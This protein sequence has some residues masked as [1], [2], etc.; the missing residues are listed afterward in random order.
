MVRA[1]VPDQPAARDAQGVGARIDQEFDPHGSPGPERDGLRPR[2]RILEVD[3]GEIGLWRRPPQRGLQRWRRLRL[4][5][6]DD[7]VEHR[8]RPRWQ[9]RNR[10]LGPQAG[11]D[12]RGRLVGDFG[13]DDQAA[14]VLL[15][16]GDDLAPLNVR[17]RTRPP[18]AGQLGDV[19]DPVDRGR[20]RSLGDEPLQGHQLTL[21]P[22]LLRDP[23]KS[24]GLRLVPFGLEHLEILVP[25]VV[26]QDGQLGPRLLQFEPIL[27]DAE[28]REVQAVLHLLVGQDVGGRR[29]VASLLQQAGRLLAEPLDALGP[30]LRAGDRRFGRLHGPLRPG[31]RRR[32]DPV[33]VFVERHLGDLAGLIRRL[34]ANPGLRRRGR[35][36]DE[37]LAQEAGIQFDDHVPLLDPRPGGQDRADRHGE[38]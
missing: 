16:V 12:P 11:P 29:G 33:L 26:L 19:D 8:P 17:P 32:V 3:H 9:V 7:A 38:R 22:L 5:R 10:H 18:R 24:L 34:E 13:V 1:V 23:R 35:L 6:L 4:D 28:P 15:D 31:L 27:L 37:G 21:L 14:V 20:D 25:G 2:G 36:G 30:L